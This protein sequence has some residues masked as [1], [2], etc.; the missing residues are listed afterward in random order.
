MKLKEVSGRFLILI[1][2]GSVLLG[3]SGGLFLSFKV[4]PK[5]HDVKVSIADSVKIE[6]TR[7]T[8]ARIDERLVR[9]TRLVVLAHQKPSTKIPVKPPAGFT[10]MFTQ[11]GI[12]LISEDLANEKRREI[13]ASGGP[14]IRKKKRHSVR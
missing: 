7:A 9:L 1:L 6:E 13:L 11:E 14:R 2:I 10:Y 12:V 4:S 8:L 5:V 3:I